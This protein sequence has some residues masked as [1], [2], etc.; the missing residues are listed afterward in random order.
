MIEVLGDSKKNIQNLLMCQTCDI[1]LSYT[2]CDAE[3][4]KLAD[5]QP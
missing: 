5:T 4:V 1:F 2:Y 3:V